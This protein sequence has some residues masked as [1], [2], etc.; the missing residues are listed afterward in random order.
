M[1]NP[2]ETR[3]K[4]HTNYRYTGGPDC[5]HQLAGAVKRRGYSATMVYPPIAEGWGVMPYY[6]ELYGIDAAEMRVENLDK[7]DTVQ[8]IPAMWGPDWYPIDKDHQFCIKA[9][10]EDAFRSTKVFYWLGIT[11]WQFWEMGGSERKVDLSHSNLQKVYHACQAQRCYDFL[12]ESGLIP[13]ERIFFVREHTVDVFMHSEEEIKESLPHRENVVL[14]NPVKGPENAESI[15]RECSDI[16]AQFVPMQ[17]MTHDDMAK[18]GMRAKVFVDFGPY[19]GREKIHREMA[20]CGCSIITGSDGSAG[21][22][23]DVPSGPRKFFRIGGHYDWVA[24]KKQILWDL[25]NHP[26]AID[27]FHMRHY[28][29]SVREEKARF[30]QDVDGMLSIID[31]YGNLVDEVSK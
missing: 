19:P 9:N 1:I 29:K 28:R 17:N 12:M 26:A 4:I 15:I 5:L 27:D 8:V 30:E 13:P 10:C 2:K 18:L 23:I 21:N 22:P 25:K 31:R 24:V 7:S 6:K 14:Y 11:N 16:D 20:V 3:F